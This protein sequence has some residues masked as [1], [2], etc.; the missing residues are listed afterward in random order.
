MMTR[1]GRFALWIA[2]AWAA[3]AQADDVVIREAIS[4]AGV[5]GGL[6]VFA[7]QSNGV[8]EIELAQTG[9]WL[10]LT[11]VPDD[12]SSRRIRDAVD[13]AGLSG[14]VT[15]ALWRSAPRLPLAD[16]MANLIVADPDSLPVPVSEDEVRR[17]LVPVRGRA[18]IKTGTG[19]RSFDRPMPA[20]LDEWT[21]FFHGPDGNAVSQDTAIRIPNALRFIAGPRLQDSNGANGYRLSDGIAVSEWNYTQS[22]DKDRRKLVVEGRDAFSGALLWQKIEPVYRGA[23]Q[24]VKTKPLILAD[25]RLL[26]MV[27]DGEQ[28]ALIGHFDPRSG[29]LVRVYRSSV[30]LRDGPYAWSA[31]PQFNYHDGLASA[32]RPAT[33]TTARRRPL[34]PARQ[35]GMA[36]QPAED[37]VSRRRLQGRAAVSA[38]RL[39]RQRR[40]PVPGPLP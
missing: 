2:V 28:S 19:W 33:R 25:G 24:S 29:E 26:R 22:G 20:G 16:H 18:L 31:E 38:V 32:A 6:A 34:P 40:R 15:V 23:P 5:T 21:H 9:R 8:R 35:S 11:V 30:N 1:T 37:R 4:E 3:V 27:D 13:E 14:L 17:V 39:R 7:G 10:V 12:A 36:S